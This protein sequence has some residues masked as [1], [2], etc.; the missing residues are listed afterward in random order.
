MDF[1][2]AQGVMRSIVGIGIEWCKFDDGISDTSFGI[3][4]QQPF[5]SCFLFTCR[6]NAAIKIFGRIQ[7]V[8]TIEIQ[9]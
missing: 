3:D 7:L 2:C 5:I 9:T 1:C 6:Q 4:R 8:D